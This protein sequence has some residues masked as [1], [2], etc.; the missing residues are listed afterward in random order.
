[1]ARHEVEMKN[2]KNMTWKYVLVGFLIVIIIALLYFGFFAGEQ[3]QEFEEQEEPATIEQR[4]SE[5]SGSYPL[6]EENLRIDNFS[7]VS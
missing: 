3:A 5:S 6:K 2:S 4:I 7:A 1:M